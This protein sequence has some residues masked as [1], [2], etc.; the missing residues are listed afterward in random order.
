MVGVLT[1]V[2]IAAFAM[3][4]IANEDMMSGDPGNMSSSTNQQSETNE[5]SQ[6]IAQNNTASVSCWQYSDVFE[7]WK[8]DCD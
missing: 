2:S 1:V 5:Q 3:P 6:D 7:E 8:W 4:A